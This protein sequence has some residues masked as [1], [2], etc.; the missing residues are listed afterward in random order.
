MEYVIITIFLLIIIFYTTRENFSFD[1]LHH[2][3]KTRVIDS[4]PRP[5][6]VDKFRRPTPCP[7]PCQQ[8]C[9]TCQYDFPVPVFGPKAGAYSSNVW[10]PGP[11]LC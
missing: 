9:K 5:Y 3:P 2:T 6:C 10:C 7:K 1:S 11:P 4:L 8:V